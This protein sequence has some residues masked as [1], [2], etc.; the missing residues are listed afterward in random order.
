MAERIFLREQVKKRE[1]HQQ[2][3]EHDTEG[4]EGLEPVM[5]SGSG[6]EKRSLWSR[7]KGKEKHDRLYGQSQG[8]LEKN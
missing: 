5:R 6:K 4:E 7:L 2:E 8:T 1:H 3:Q